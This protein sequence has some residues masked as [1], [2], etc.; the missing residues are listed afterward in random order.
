MKFEESS[1]A[2][3][4]IESYKAKD[5]GRY[6]T[7]K[8][9][10]AYQSHSVSKL[11]NCPRKVVWQ[12][13][14]PISDTLIEYLIRG[15]SI[16]SAF[17]ST[18]AVTEEYLDYE[19]IHA[20]VDMIVRNRPVE[21]YTTAMSKVFTPD[22]Y[23]LK[24]AQLMAYIKMLKELGYKLEENVGEILIYHLYKKEQKLMSY[25]ISF[26]SEEIED[27]WRNIKYNQ[28]Q[29]REYVSSGKIPEMNPTATD[30]YFECR[31]CEFYI[32]CYGSNINGNIVCNPSGYEG[33]DMRVGEIL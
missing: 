17:E 24:V 26:E 23:P 27:N 4:V 33:K 1:L 9:L 31:K 28:N 29:L 2:K 30:E 15:T 18:Q 32:R 11:T 12:A 20:R 25:K 6:K 13:E 8:E 3:E 10:I 21:G 16:H 14:K 22:E 19:Q 5:R 7:P